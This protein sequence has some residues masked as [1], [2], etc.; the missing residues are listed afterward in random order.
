MTITN[1]LGAASLK[2]RMVAWGM[3]PEN[4]DHWGYFVLGVPTVAAVILAEETILRVLHVGVLL[5]RDVILVSICVVT[6]LI[7]TSLPKRKGLVLSIALTVVCFRLLIAVIEGAQGALGLL[8][9]NA[10]LLGGILVI[11]PSLRK[12]G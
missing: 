5:K 10:V 11:D 3:K 7:L 12:N 8:L 6:T 2:G 9:A 4:A 1:H